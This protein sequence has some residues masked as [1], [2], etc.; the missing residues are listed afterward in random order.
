MSSVKGR[1]SAGG[2]KQG[3]TWRNTARAIL[4]RL[5]AE[6]C[7]FATRGGG[8][9]QGAEAMKDGRGFRDKENFPTQQ[10]PS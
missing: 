4:P 10:P 1:I 6:P 5:L 2:R 9:S 8:L 7:Y 3:L